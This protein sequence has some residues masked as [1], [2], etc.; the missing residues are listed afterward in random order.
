MRQGIFPYWLESTMINFSFFHT[1]SL[2]I[3]QR[4]TDKYPNSV[5]FTKFPPC[6]FFLYV[7]S[8]RSENR[9]LTTH[10]VMREARSSV[11]PRSRGQRNGFHAVYHQR[12]MVQNSQE[13]RLKYWATRSSVH[14]FARTAHSFAC[15]GLLASL[16]PSAALIRLPARSLR[17]LP[18]LW[19]SD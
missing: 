8:L 5:F 2:R 4:G 13:Y 15:S 6:F 7:F 3:N 17:S 18:R 11:L 1:L 16:A 12:T 10:R 19:D 14:S 9:H